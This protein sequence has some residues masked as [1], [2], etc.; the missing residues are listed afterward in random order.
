MSAVL[1]GWYE[2]DAV[3]RVSA[4]A[5]ARA[6]L[7][8]PDSLRLGVCPKYAIFPP[9]ISPVDFPLNC[10]EPFFCVR[11][12]QRSTQARVRYK[13]GVR[14]LVGVPTPPF[15]DRRGPPPTFLGDPDRPW[16]VPPKG[17]T[18]LSGDSCESFLHF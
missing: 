15:L 3:S 7:T 10:A 2:H 9:D 11:T 16:G 1:D 18:F 5:W 6:L 12:S 4:N 14:V 13:A 8:R 17:Q